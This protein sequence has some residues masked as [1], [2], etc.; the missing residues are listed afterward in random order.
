M[1]DKPIFFCGCILL[2]A[3][4]PQKDLGLILGHDPSV[5]NH[6]CLGCLILKHTSFD[7]SFKHALHIYNSD[8]R[9]TPMSTNTAAHVH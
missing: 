9:P 4:I 7:V 3:F 2:L 6:W 1:V 8:Y 5:E